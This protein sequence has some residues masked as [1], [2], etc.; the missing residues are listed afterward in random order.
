MGLTTSVANGK[1]GSESG[2]TSIFLP[3]VISVGENAFH[4]ALL[5]SL[6]L[7]R[8]ITI[9]ENAFASI[10]NVPTTHVT[11]QGKFNTNAGKDR[12][13]GPGT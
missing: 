8:A 1:F 5:T 9:G 2:L 10:V 4:N 12:I 13:F 6:S 3:E 7:P 11:M